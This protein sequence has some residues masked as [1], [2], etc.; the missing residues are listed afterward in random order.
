MKPLIGVTSDK[1]Q[2]GDILVETRYITAVRQAGGIPI[3]LP[4]NL[5]AVEEMCGYLDGLM[6]IGGEDVDPSYFGEEPHRKLGKVMPD[7]DEMELALIKTMAEQD[8]PVLGICRGYQLMNVACG[9]TIYQDI[10]AQLSE[11]LQQHHQVTELEYATHL[12][13]VASGSRLAEWA[14]ASEVR[15]NTLHHQAI[16]DIKAPLVVTATA[17]D[18]VI[19]AFESDAHSFFVGVQWHPEA[20]V[21]RNDPTSLRLFESFVEACK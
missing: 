13:D 3:I 14:G 7:R 6:L 17:K 8:K 9:G 4:V 5:E 10:Y 16:K 20:L 2:Q 21:K 12:V 11:D 19:E 15:V 18:G 1:D